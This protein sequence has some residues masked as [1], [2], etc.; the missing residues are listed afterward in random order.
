MG[1]V[2]WKQSNERTNHNTIKQKC[3]D[4]RSQ[5]MWHGVTLQHADPY[6][7]HCQVRRVPHGSPKSRCPLPCVSIVADS[8]FHID[9]CQITLGCFRPAEFTFEPMESPL[10][11]HSLWPS[12]FSP[13]TC[14][15][16]FVDL[17]WSSDLSCSPPSLV[18]DGPQVLV[19]R[20]YTL[21][22]SLIPTPFI[23]LCFTS[24]LALLH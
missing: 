22:S 13:G 23:S 4:I 12:A 2:I 18:Q 7:P 20:P 16:L 15:L 21:V 10:L 5:V 3:C 9:T 6:L 1:H 14:R 24:R 8:E 19:S 11:T 17:S